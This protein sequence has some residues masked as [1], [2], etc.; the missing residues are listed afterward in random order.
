MSLGLVRFAVQYSYTVPA[1]GS[2][3]PDPTPAFIS[4]VH[5]LYFSAL[6]FV[7]TVVVGVVVTLLTRP[8]EERCV[9]CGWE[10]FMI[11]IWL[12][13]VMMRIWLGVAMIRICLGVVMIQIFLGVVMIQI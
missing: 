10:W 13:V 7:A 3:L 11:R 6:L 5:Y 4:R 9:S 8:M 2:G 1:C 12:G